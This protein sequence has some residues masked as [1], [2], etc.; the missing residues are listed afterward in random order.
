VILRASEL[1]DARAHHDMGR[2][3]IPARVAAG[4]AWV[5][6]FGANQVPGQSERER[7]YWR[8][9]GSLDAYYQASMD[10]VAIHP[11]FDLYNYRWPILT[12]MYP[13]PPAKFVH[14]AGE[15]VG[16][17]TNSIVSAGCITNT[18]GKNR[19][20]S[21]TTFL[22]SCYQLWSSLFDLEFSS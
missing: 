10:L 17:A 7:S 5:Y 1:G 8:D 3:I 11:I 22:S 12:W 14:E 9:V 6:D 15:R 19:P 21:A 13:H 4:D 2:N 16:T 20:E 18:S